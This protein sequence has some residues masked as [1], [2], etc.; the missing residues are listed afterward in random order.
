MEINKRFEASNNGFSYDIIF[1]YKQHGSFT[2]CSHRCKECSVMTPLRLL[3]RGKAPLA[4][5]VTCV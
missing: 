1:S 3:F 2:K 5:Y 4:I